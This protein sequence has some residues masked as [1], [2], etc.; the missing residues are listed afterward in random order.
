MT[1][2]DPTVA[3]G[4]A[5]LRDQ[6]GIASEAPD[7]RHD[8]PGPSARIGQLV[9][10]ANVEIERPEWI[11]RDWYPTKVATMISGKGGSGKSSLTIA[12]IAA[13]T[14]GDLHGRCYGQPMRAIIMSVE[15]SQGMQKTRLRAAGAD[16]RYV[17]FFTVTD[18]E[19]DE[20]VI[21]AIPG[22]LIELRRLAAEFKADVIV[23]DPLSSVVRG[24]LDK[25]TV[26]REALDPLTKLARALNIAVVV[27][28]HH[29]KG[30]GASSDLAA[31][32]HAIRDV[33]RS[34]LLVAYD[35]END[36]R[37]IT[38]DKSN[39]S[40]L[41]GTSLAFELRSGPMVDDDGKSIVDSEGMQET[42]PLAVVTGAASTSVE[43]I[44]NRIPA[45]GGDAED[46][47]ACQSFLVD[48][49]ADHQLEAPAGDVMKAGRAAGF[50]DQELKDARRRC[51]DPRI[52]S[53]KASFGSGWVWAIDAEGGTAE[54]E[55][56]EGGS[57]SDTATFAT[58]GYPDATF[59]TLDSGTAA[60]AEPDES[61]VD[62]GPPYTCPRCSKTSSLWPIHPGCETTTERNAA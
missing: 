54:V 56:G 62:P 2:T 61:P 31:N 19:T 57:V 1:I 52:R 43:E 58:L 3:A 59:G 53:R 55:G 4:M 15:D 30:G 51:H 36:E 40:T 41:E 32:S 22:D 50:S 44:V 45:A 8:K 21:P 25:S 28:H 17:R 49:L 9:D 34:S 14:R 10:P 33:V 7:T 5:E 47:N 29:R 26:I 37:V 48:Y 6:Y 18:T 13:G 42:V 27:V 23:V 38:F 24:N 12:D 46:R 11:K 60:D 20:D 35:K 16:L 39:Y